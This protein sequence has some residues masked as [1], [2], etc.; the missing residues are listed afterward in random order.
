M[1]TF[2]VWFDMNLQKGLGIINASDRTAAEKQVLEALKE[3]SSAD[4]ELLAT[5]EIALSEPSLFYAD[6]FNPQID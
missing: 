2:A 6:E 1:K 3:D 4:I 5:E